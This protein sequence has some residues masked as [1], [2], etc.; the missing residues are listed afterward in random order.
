MVS[1]GCSK[2]LVDSE[3]ILTLLKSFSG[4]S[5][6]SDPREADIA[7][8]N[9]CAFIEEATAESIEAIFAIK[10]CL[11]KGACLVVLGC[12]PA[13][14]GENI[15]LAEADLILPR[16]AYSELPELVSKVLSRKSNIQTAA[17]LSPEA[18]ALP[19]D[20]WERTVS[21]PRWRA[22]LKISEGCNHKCTYCMIP[23]IRGPLKSQSPDSLLKEAKS[24]ANNGVV[25]L[26]LVAQDLTAYRS[27]SVGLYELV[28]RLGDIDKLKWIRLM[29]CY[30]ERLS[31]TLLKN[32]KKVEKLVPYIDVPFQHASPR[33]LELMGRKAINPMETVDSIRNAWPELSLR[34]TLLTG[35]PGEKERDFELMLKFLEKAKFDYA[36][37]FKFSAEE[38]SRAAN[39]P[40]QVPKPIKTRRWRAL[41]SLQKKISHKLNRKRVGQ[42]LKILVDGFA[43]ESNV[44]TVGRGTFQAPEVDGLVYFEGKQPKHG[45]IVRATIIAAKGYDLLSVLDD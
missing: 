38:G 1:M 39:F 5:Q 28:R 44:F 14:Y 25:E 16:D 17:Q 18:K 31:P 36:G 26:T 3:R 7:V 22:Y 12:L 13:R 20:S 11:K 34:T 40:N 30:P 2:N 37:F 24:L 19:F 23:K 6:T 41:S 29:Y 4:V 15:K 42:S 32:L 27:G 45:K 43:H 9:T 8:I 33:I 35:F 21:T 10:G